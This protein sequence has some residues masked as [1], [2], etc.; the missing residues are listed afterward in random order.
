MLRRTLLIALA[1][2]VLFVTLLGACSRSDPEKELRA[3]VDAMQAAIQAKNT[4]GFLD[5]VADDFTRESGNFDKKEARRILAGVFL[6]HQS[7]NVVSTVRDIKIDGQR[8]TA[9]ITVLATGSS[10]LLPERG[11][12]WTFSTHWRREAGAWRVFNAEWKEALP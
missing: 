8:A 9:Q 4:S 7:I 1:Q 6:T 5:H 2:A 11:Q 12:S 10:G 3:A